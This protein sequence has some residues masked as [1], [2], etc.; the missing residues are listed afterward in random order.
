V[1]DDPLTPRDPTRVVI[2]AYLLALLCLLLPL[3]L[4]GAIYAGAVLIRHGRPMEG[5]GVLVLGVACTA[6]GIALLR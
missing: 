3:A 5:G 1:T 2:V 4:I 6:I